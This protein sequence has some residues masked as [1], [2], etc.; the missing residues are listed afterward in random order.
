MYPLHEPPQQSRSSEH[1]SP[2][3]EHTQVAPPSAVSLPPM[4]QQHWMY[5]PYET[6]PGCL[7]EQWPFSQKS[8]PH[9]MSLEQG[10]PSFLPEHDRYVLS[11]YPEQQSL[12]DSQKPPTGGVAGKQSQ[13][14]FV[15]P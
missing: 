6:S 15:Q 3:G 14:P 2:R 10:A 13:T 9:T 7:H 1:G 11:Q 12:S 5:V 8:S 4:S